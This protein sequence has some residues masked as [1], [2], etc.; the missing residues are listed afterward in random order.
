MRRRAS[1]AM[2]IAGLWIAGALV[3]AQVPTPP[4]QSA[5]LSQ[6]A[7]ATTTAQPAETPA[8][9]AT[10][11]TT[12][13][14]KLHGIVKSGNIPL[15]GV[16]IT[17]QNTLTGKRFSTT[18][19]ITGAWSMTIPQNGRYVIRTQFA[20]FAQGSQE[21]LLNAT[22]RD[23]TV[24]FDLK[25]AS[26]AAEEEQQQGQASQMQQA[27]RQLTGSGL[28]S[29]SLMSSLTGDTEAGAGGSQVANVAS[30]PSVAGNSDFSGD[31]VTITGQSGSVS[32]LAGVDMDRIRDFVE[33]MRAQNGGQGPGGGPGAGAATAQGQAA[34]ILG[35][36]GGPFF[37]AGGF[38]GGF[39][40]G[41]FGGG[42]FGG[43]GGGFGGGGGR[44]NFRGFN[45]SQPHGSVFWTGS[46]SAL[47]A[48]PYSLRGQP[49]EQPA[50]GSNRFGVTLMGAPYIPGLTKPSG[51]DTVFLTA[52]GV[53]SS[54]PLDEYAT[55]PTDAERSGII[56]GLSAPITP[57]PEAEAL[58]N[59]IPEPNLPGETQN[60]H[61]LT[62]AQSN[63]T[64]AGVRYMRGLGANATPFGGR[65]GGGGA[66]RRSTQS[67]GLRQSINFNYNWAHTASDNVNVFPDLGGKT[68]S[69]SNSVQAG[70]T[71][72]YHKLTSIFNASWNRA[73][74]HATNYFTNTT[75]VATQ[76]GILGPDGNPLNSSPLNYGLPNV[77]LSAF[78]GLN[79]Q[80]PKFSVSQTLSF[81][82]T[83]AWIHGKHNLRFGGDYRRVHRDFLG[84]LDSTGSFYF[85]GFYTGSSLGDFLLG[86]PQSTSIDV[87][88]SKSYLR[89]NVFDLYAQ[90]DWRMRSNL[91]LLYGIRYEFFAPYTEKYNHLSMIDT[92]PSG[93]FSN[94]AQVQAGGAG[95]SSGKLPDSL[96]YPFRVAFAPRLGVAWRLP[97]QTVVRAGYGMNYTTSSYAA[98]ANTMALQPPFANLQSNVVETTC[99]T[100]GAGC[101]SLGNGFPAPDAFGSYA[102][103]PHYRLPYVQAWNV[104]IQKTLPWGIVMN[105]GYNGSKGSNLDVTIAPRY[106]AAT[107]ETN[108]GNV[109][110]NYEQSAAFS[111]FN[112]GT[113]RVNK[114]LSNGIAIGANYQYSHSIDNAG[115]VGGTSTVVA[116]NWQDILA[117]E[118][119]SS[120][121]VRHKVSGNYLYELPFGK[122]KFWVTTG[123][124]S[125]VLEGFSISGTFTFATGAS[126]TPS[127]QATIG[128]V[129]RGTAGT[130]RPDRIPGSSLTEGGGSLKHWF[131]TAAFTAPAGPYGTASRYSIPGPGIVQNNM[132]LSKTM[133][134]GETRSFEVRAT[135]NNVFNT[136]QYSTVATT[137][138]TGTE[139]SSNSPFGQVT[140]VAA[141]RSFQFNARFRF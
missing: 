115:S 130:Q 123:T 68:A 11:A 18:T 134:L 73:D 82:E 99:P 114:R 98:F 124:W 47:N 15:P 31:S 84:G 126:L 8:S 3:R 36:G 21:A 43:R 65:G 62:T 90:D 33:S 48:E 88:E 102:V 91:T 64:Q 41:G 111:N 132:S 110:F 20:A 117:E 53:R 61:L 89:E 76:V 139:A 85:T 113:L 77:T 105:A 10:I 133:Q 119:N 136:V 34:G 26:R 109:L 5:P 40:D 28:Q 63:T 1:T 79:E 32:P 121:D 95:P 67:Q 19:D 51:K 125:H 17:A 54:S 128:D 141:M 104:D 137:L 46:N 27:I 93:A 6:T 107:P 78:T 29:L 14:G 80:Q 81:S 72:G 59:Y 37:S 69:D 45:P 71:L 129:Q 38:G 100:T 9:P 86:L 116:Q 16:T 122:D 4:A 135:A 108:P 103:D 35:G 101:L 120:F 106:S 83:L 60:Y 66:G 22:S 49:Q 57:V 140:G 13:G 25:L 127:Y 74:S 55:V 12:A 94:V 118:S 39:G 112:A 7:P 52:S 92:N 87:T 2:V 44:G 97:K 96:V 131:N 70:Y 30:L 50:S 138:F 56:P 23:Q 75:D 58:L 42:G 24:N